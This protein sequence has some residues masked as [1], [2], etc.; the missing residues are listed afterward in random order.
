M[1]YYFTGKI[2]GE[3]FVYLNVSDALIDFK[4]MF[5]DD[6]NWL[7][8]RSLLCICVTEFTFENESFVLKAKL[9]D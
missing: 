6:I 4:R 8:L 5:G 3:Q 9:G 2:K 1:R 7:I